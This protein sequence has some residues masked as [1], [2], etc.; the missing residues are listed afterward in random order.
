MTVDYIMG[1]QNPASSVHT[2]AVSVQ[3]C[4]YEAPGLEWCLLWDV[5]YAL[6]LVWFKGT[7]LRLSMEAPALEH[8]TIVQ[9]LFM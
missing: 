3:L 6:V 8:Y 4:C 7:V 5:L 2:I 9:N 1:P